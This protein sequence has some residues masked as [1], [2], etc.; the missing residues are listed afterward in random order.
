MY[1]AISSRSLALILVCKNSVTS[2]LSPGLPVKWS[3][4]SEPAFLSIAPISLTTKVVKPVVV[5]SKCRSYL[6]CLIDFPNSCI[7]S[8]CSFS[9][10]LLSVIVFHDK[11]IFCN[12]RFPEISPKN[13]FICLGTS[14]FDEI[15]KFTSF[16]QDYTM[17]YTTLSENS[18][19]LTLTND[20]VLN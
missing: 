10:V 3:A 20:S 6:L 17:S 13:L 9:V 2:L 15:S 14:L 1:L 19:R 8:I 11:L 18:L 7:I 12:L 5:K 4:K 16:L